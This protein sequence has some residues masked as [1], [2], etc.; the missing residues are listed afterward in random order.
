MVAVAALAG[1]AE[2]HLAGSLLYMEPYG[3][4]KLDC[5][6]LKKHAAAASGRVK[7]QQDL[8]DRASGSAAG[9]VINSVVY[10]PDYS[11]ARFEQRVYE[12]E[13][14]RRNCDPPP[15]LALD[16]AQ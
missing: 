10:G 15:P 6:Q 13:I 1:C 7:T 3:Y 14:A 11:K 4:E 5:D 2:S 8:M 12:R 16:P 9:P